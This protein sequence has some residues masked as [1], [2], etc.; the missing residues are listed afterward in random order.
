MDPMAGRDVGTIQRVKVAS[1]QTVRL[2]E[3]KPIVMYGTSEDMTTEAWKALRSNDWDHAIDQAQATIQE[4]SIAGLF[5]QKK[6]MQEVGHLLKPL[7]AYQDPALQ[8]RVM[9]AMAAA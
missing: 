5:L 2:A 4:W 7:S 1:P 3:R 9:E 6:K 8:R